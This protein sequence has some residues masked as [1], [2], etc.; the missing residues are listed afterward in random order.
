[1]DPGFLLHALIPSWNSVSSFTLY[2]S[3]KVPKI[4]YRP[5]SYLMNFSY[6]WAIRLLS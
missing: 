4:P 6:I 1:M 3:P 2:Q 5:I